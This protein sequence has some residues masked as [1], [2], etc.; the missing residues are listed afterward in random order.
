MA[1]SYEEIISILKYARDN[2][3]IAAAQHF[4]VASSTV[5]RWN[6]KYKIYETQVMRTFSVE[7][8]I[9]MLQYANQ[10][11]LTN[12]MNHYSI[13]VATLQ[14]WNKKLHVYKQHGQKR[15]T[16]T[17]KLPER[18]SEEFKRLVLECARDNGP[19][20]AA[21]MY[22]V[23]ASTIRLWNKELNVYPTRAHRTFT[24]EQRAEIIAYANEHGIATAAHKFNVVG[25]QIQNWID[26]QHSL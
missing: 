12:A 1:Y 2:G 11:G 13:D 24:P 22:N 6:N 20:K 8:K 3:T 18:K 21:R 9:E 23:A 26:D 19:S 25:F 10:H 16:T 4:G 7:Q 17:N 14:S 5:V 15:A